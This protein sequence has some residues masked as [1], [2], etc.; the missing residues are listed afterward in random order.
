MKVLILN[1]NSKEE[2]GK[3]DDYIER[4]AD[5]LNGGGHRAT[6]MKLRDMKINHCIGCYSCWLKT[7][8]I[9]AL[10]DDGEKVLSEYINSDFVLFSSPIV[11]G[12]VSALLKGVQERMLPLVHPFLYV[13]KDRSQHM[14]RYE[15]YPACGLLLDKGGD[16]GEVSSEIIGKVFESSKSRSFAFTKSMEASPEEIVNEISNI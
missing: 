13:M 15:K 9:C 3:F 16:Y 8:G 12:F 10:K 5:G 7:P 2:N 4:L 11:M 1:G 14:P 6:V